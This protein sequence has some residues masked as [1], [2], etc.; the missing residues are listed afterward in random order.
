M[1]VSTSAVLDASNP[2]IGPSHS[3]GPGQPSIRGIGE[4]SRCCWWV[5]VSWLPL[6][7]TWGSTPGLPS[8]GELEPGTLKCSAQSQVSK[9]PRDT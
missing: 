6:G 2:C 7:S 3:G 5:Y 4:Y 1:A 9:V 8:E